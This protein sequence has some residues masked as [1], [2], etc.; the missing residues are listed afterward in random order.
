MKR[1]TVA[2]VGC[3]HRGVVHLDAVR[4]NGDR[5]ELVGLCDL[6]ATKL[7]GVAG[8]RGITC[9]YTD[10]ETML[11]ETKPDVFSFVTQPNVRLSMVELAARHG[12]QG[13]SFEKPM[14]TSLRE[15]RAI[16]DLCVAHGIKAA[17]SHQQKY[18][19]S[20]QHLKAIVDAG[21]LGEV[22]TV[23][24]TTLAWLSQLGTHFVDYALWINGGHH[25]MW[26]CGH[27]HG[28]SGLYDSHPSC[29]YVAGTMEFANGVHGYV[30]FGYLCPR[31][32]PD[33]LPDG[34]PGPRYWLDN[35]L[36]VYGTHGYA[37]ADT[38][39]RWGAF[40]RAS[41]GEAIG[42]EGE[43]WGVQEATHL[44]PS[45]FRD[46]ADW[47]DD[48]GVHPCNLEIS[49]HGY[50]IMEGLCVSAL[51]NRRV[52]LPFEDRGAYEDVIERMRRELQEVP[53]RPAGS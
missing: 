35:R 53:A 42:E 50:E 52:D 12:V 29:D 7:A 41:K 19:T 4:Q 34:R 6:D 44:Q 9:T 13:L 33:S 15:A 39:G 16:R 2:Q 51:E 37:W 31:H 5:F 17:V 20:M 45:Y 21:D 18:L 25:A 30:E 8:P 22:Q 24:A 26:V 27:V 1:Y 46:L 23:Q 49:V 10:A 43:P 48:A 47:L 40:T 3:G 38:D 11:A 32:M 14:A 36:T 28:R